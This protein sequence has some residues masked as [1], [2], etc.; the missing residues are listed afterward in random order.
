MSNDVKQRG[1]IAAQARRIAHRPERTAWRVALAA[2]STDTP[3]NP[4]PLQRHPYKG[5]ARVV[6]FVGACRVC[7]GNA[8]SH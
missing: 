1:R 7:R 2:A 6:G 4:S 5:V 3:H 8:L